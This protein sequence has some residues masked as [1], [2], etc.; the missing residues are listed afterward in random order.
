MR[1][2]WILLQLGNAGRLGR[3]VWSR[4]AGRV[5]AAW[6]SECAA[7]VALVTWVQ[8]PC[9]FC[10][11]DSDTPPC[12]VPGVYQFSLQAPTPLLASLPAAVPMPSG[13]PQPATRTLV[14]T[15]NTQVRGRG[16]PSWD[17]PGTASELRLCLLGSG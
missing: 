8:P 13:K 3:P 5:G 7:G 9:S 17:G 2:L 4:G 12:T 16:C 10:S 11:Q 15:S 6:E 1:F 14:V